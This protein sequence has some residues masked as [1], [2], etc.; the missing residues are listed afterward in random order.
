MQCFSTCSVPPRNRLSF[1]NEIAGSALTQME[2]HSS[3]LY[4]FA[5]TLWNDDL[6][7]LGISKAI[8]TIAQIRRTRAQIAHCGERVFLINLSERGTFTVSQR[9]REATLFEGDF[10]INDSAEPF[11]LTHHSPCEAVVIRVPEKLMRCYLPMPED[12][13][14]LALSGRRGMGAI[15][16]DTLRSLCRQMESGLCAQMDPGAADPVM[17][18]VASACASQAQAMIPQTRTVALRRIAIKQ[19]IEAR[20]RDPELSPGQL[21]AAFRISDRYVR[22]V[23]GAEGESASAY[24]LRRRLEECAKRLRDPLWHTRSVSEIAFAWAFNS[25]G[26]FDRAFK[27]RYG[28]P[29]HDFRRGVSAP[30]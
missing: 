9:G 26:S 19:F 20:L 14:G 25:L 6:G 17:E 16:S 24:I 3:D 1:W 18:L 29:P 7:P 27:A 11:V 15:A 2:I 8:S 23:F 30:D 21:A 4:G 10:T 22:V 13:A 28:V 5:G 12:L